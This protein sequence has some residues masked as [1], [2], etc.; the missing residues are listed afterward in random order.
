MGSTSETSAAGPPG[1]PQPPLA[2]CSACGSGFMQPRSWR[3][4]PNGKL[5]LELRCPECLLRTTG[6]YEPAL[7]ADYDRA[8]VAGR[9]EIS[10]LCQAVTRANMEAEAARLARALDLDLIGADDFAGYNR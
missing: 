3:A 9:L 6:D 10:A 1:T 2:C 5:R 7:V 4:R 8:L